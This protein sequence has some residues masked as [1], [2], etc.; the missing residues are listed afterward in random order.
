MPLIKRVAVCLLITASAFTRAPSF[1]T[2]DLRPAQSA[3]PQNARVRVLP[4]GDL[5]GTSVNTI[6]LIADAYNVPANPSE[7]LSTLPPW[8]YSERYDIA[9]RAPSNAK[10]MSPDGRTSKLIRD[11]F[12]QL[13]ADQFHLVMRVD[14]RM[15]PVY[16]LVVA[17]GG[18]KA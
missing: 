13:L 8:V 14:N 6:A 4:N 15:M 2:I 1:A 12:R 17:R 7:R 5:I 9:A 18:P 3:D 11:L 16:T 10:Q